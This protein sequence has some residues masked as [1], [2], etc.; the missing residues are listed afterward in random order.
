[1]LKDAETNHAPT[2]LGCIR[3]YFVEM[4]KFNKDWPEVRTALDRWIAFLNKAEGLNRDNLPAQLKEEPAILKASAE[5][6]RIGLDP[7][8]R[9]IYESEV[10]AVMVDQIQLK[11]AEERGIQQGM[12]QGIQQG[13]QQGIQQ[14]MQQGK[15][16]MVL[17]L[18]ARRVGEVPSNIITQLNGLSANELDDLSVDLLD[19][20]SSTEIERWLTRH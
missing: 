18:I 15:R 12:Q 16:N 3:L 6:E 5:L 1:M 20:T 8:E 7:E 11:T 19:F 10:K 13:V 2:E 4:G 9:E 14:G 17:R